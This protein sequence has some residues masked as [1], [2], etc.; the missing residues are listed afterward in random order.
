MSVKFYADNH[1]YESTDLF[2]GIEWLSVSRLVSKFHEEFDPI[3]ASE[4]ATKNRNSKWYKI[5]VQEIR[6]RWDAEG[7]RS[8]TLGTWYHDKQEAKVLSKPTYNYNGIELPVFRPEIVD[9]IKIAPDQKLVEGIYPEHFV[10][11]KSIGVCGQSDKVKIVNGHI[12]VNDFKTSKELKVEGFKNWEGITKKMLPPLAHLDDANLIHYALQLSTYAH[13]IWKHNP[14][15]IVDNPIIEHVI[16]EIESEDEF[17]YPIMKLDENG[18][19]IVKE[20]IE[21]PVP[22]MKREVELMFD[23]IKRQKQLK[24]V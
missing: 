24:N 22:Y 14:S 7:T 12:K 23:S 9:G 11:L 13:I 4:K 10:Y 8:T 15:Y 6:D 2:E 5:D 16:F 20:V 19:P 21:I 18:E 17:G 1:K 3:K